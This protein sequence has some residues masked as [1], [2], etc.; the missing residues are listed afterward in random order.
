[1]GVVTKDCVLG[2]NWIATSNYVVAAELGSWTILKYIMTKLT[3][4]VTNL[5]DF[6][7]KQNL[8][9]LLLYLSLVGLAVTTKEVGVSTK[10]NILKKDVWDVGVVISLIAKESAGIS[11]SIGN[12]IGQFLR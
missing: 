1:V 10:S 5:V 11:S 6:H 9:V 4:L 7:A 2:I 8:S 3:T 12:D